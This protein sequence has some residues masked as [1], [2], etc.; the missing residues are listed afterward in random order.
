MKKSIIIFL[1]IYSI[2][3]SMSAFSK[4]LRTYTDE[5]GETWQI[6]GPDDAPAKQ[7]TNKAPALK[8]SPPSTSPAEHKKDYW[9]YRDDAHKGVIS[10]G[11]PRD[12]VIESWGNPD[13]INKSTGR[14]G[15]HEQWVYLHGGNYMHIP[16]RDYVYIDNGVVTGWQ[17]E[18]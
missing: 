18:R 13:K 3:Y 10:R 6:I 1:V 12:L 2:L 7:A 15:V 4:V 5:K 9:D 8:E 16:K 11:M 17:T 14:F